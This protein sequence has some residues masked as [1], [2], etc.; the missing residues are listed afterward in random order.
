MLKIRMQRTGRKNDP[1]FRV[2]V[3]EHTMG[4][5]SGRFLEKLGFYDPHT[6][7]QTLNKERIEYW[8]SKGAQ[9]SESMHNMLINAKILSG[10]KI[11]VLPKKSPP[12]KE[13][14]EE[15]AVASAAPVA[16]A[17]KAEES[18][19]GQSGGDTGATDAGGADGASA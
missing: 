3:G 7:Q 12:K 15:A 16:A 18:E 17:E 13:D 9:V 6:K 5:K 14:K 1:S 11:N 8:I 19:A 4:P 2:V 10:K